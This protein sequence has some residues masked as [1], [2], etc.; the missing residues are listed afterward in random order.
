MWVDSSAHSQTVWGMLRY[1]RNTDI[2]GNSKTKIASTY[3]FTVH[4]EEQMLLPR[5]IADV[6]I[7]LMTGSW[8]RCMSSCP[9]LSLTPIFIC[10]IWI[11]INWALWNP[12]IDFN[13]FNNPVCLWS[14]PVSS[15]SPA[16]HKILTSSA[17]SGYRF[18]F[19]SLQTP[20]PDPLFKFFPSRPAIRCL[21]VH[22]LPELTGYSMVLF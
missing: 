18:S 16:N 11:L 20:N 19:L 4:H 21:S 17:V 5:I 3:E 15:Q 13:C 9:I 12:I 1:M 14:H 10:Y 8:C 22:P 7:C 2:S 6:G